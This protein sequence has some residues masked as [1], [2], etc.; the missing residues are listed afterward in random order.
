MSFVLNDASTQQMSFFDAYDTL[1]T[2]EKKFLEKSWAKYFAE[3][4][5]PKIDEKPYAVLYSEKDSRPN[6]PVNIQVGALIIKEFMGMS[7]E[8]MLAALM[9]DI[10]FQ[11]ALHTTSFQEQPMSDRTLGRFRERCS[12]YEK[13]TG[14]DLL[15]DTIV[16]LSVEMAEMMKLD[17]SLKRM[18]S[19][20]VSSN[21]KKMSRL[22]LVYTCVANLV[23]EVAK[24]T[25]ELPE[26]LK[27]YIQADDRNRVIYH[28]RSEE[29]SA[30]I[31]VILKDA[32]N[33]KQLCGS[34]Y[35]ESSSYQLLLRV[36][37]EQ[38]IAQ[39]D[40]ALRL[41]TKEDGGMN[42]SILQNPADPDAT[43]REKAGKQN[44]GYVANVTEAAGENGSIV[45]GYQYEKNIYSDSQFMK[46][47][48]EQEEVHPQPA[49]VV[50]DGA[51]SGRD[52]EEVAAEKNV[53]LVVTNLTG[54]ESEDIAADFEFNEEGTKVEKC[55]GGF[56]PKSCSY[57]PQTGQCTASFHRSQCEQC[58]HKDQCHPKFFK[59][60]CRKSISVNTKR[61][62]QQQ[63]YRGTEE[64]KKLSSF[65]NGV[66]T[67]P[68]I[69]RRKY[70]VDHMPIRGLV[71]SK[72]FFGCKIAALNF[73]K[74]CKYM[75]GCINHAPN[76]AIA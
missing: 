74:F 50:A 64:F 40:G 13:E 45:T 67:I 20:M 10:R 46:D 58:P 27:H 76:T 62:A 59:R 42:A 53:K 36:L 18:D 23:K 73:S 68:S 48:L 43:Y 47:Y 9:F 2:R 4:I 6:T 38:T 55:A 3:H 44:R 33:L 29:T 71:R 37:K 60:T 7:D 35:D 1:T 65:R 75:Q 61:R 30:R 57:N 25:E 5:F 12:S 70:Q 32:E 16:S 69:L 31:A 66:E 26:G 63:R 24:H 15:H 34:S 8:E 41:R 14:I 22:E 21:I 56:E 19:L 51:Y 39:E 28:N 52:N 54:R 17:L 11:Y 72:L 49:T